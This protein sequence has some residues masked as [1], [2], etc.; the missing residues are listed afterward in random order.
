MWI[1]DELDIY[2]CGGVA[3]WCYLMIEK[4][5]LESEVLRENFGLI[6][7]TRHCSFGFELNCK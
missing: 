2:L 7:I 1:S 4:L 3:L 6:T 5:C